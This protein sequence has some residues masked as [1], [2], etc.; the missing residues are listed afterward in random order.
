MNAVLEKINGIHEKGMEKVFKGE[1]IHFPGFPKTGLLKSHVSLRFGQ[2]SLEDYRYRLMIPMKS[3][4]QKYGVGLIC[5]E[6]DYPFHATIGQGTGTV[7]FDEKD[8]LVLS[9]GI[10]ALPIFFSQ[11]AMDGSNVLLAVSSID[12]EVISLRKEVAEKHAA[13]G[14]KVDTPENILHVSVA[15]II[16]GTPHAIKEFAQA[17]CLL[18]EQILKIGR[19]SCRERV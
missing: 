17:V 6:I 2:V 11:V 10:Y 3:A 7:D 8:C 14:L 19:A 13:L 9:L 12:P 16:S 1:V 15:R 4:A 5:A 18:R